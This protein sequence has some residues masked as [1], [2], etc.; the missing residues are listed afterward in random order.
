MVRVTE[1]PEPLPKEGVAHGC[2]Y[3]LGPAKARLGDLVIEFDTPEHCDSFLR[4][5]W[6][7]GP[8]FNESNRLHIEEASITLGLASATESGVIIHT[9]RRLGRK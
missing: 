8:R 2:H 4:S 6:L 5:G 9:S 1:E 3:T 7:V